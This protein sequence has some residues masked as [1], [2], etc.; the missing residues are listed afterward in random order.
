MSH[1][2]GDVYYLDYVYEGPL[3]GTAKSRKDPSAVSD[4]V[5]KIFGDRLIK[6][7]SSKTIQEQ[8]TRQWKVDIDDVVL[9]AF[10]EGILESLGDTLSNSLEALSK[11]VFEA[12]QAKD[13][14]T[15]ETRELNKEAISKTVE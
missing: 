2:V 6:V 7:M 8:I 13:K 14:K 5:E 4:I 12:V 11:G 1:P 9:D 10:R 15:L 3:H